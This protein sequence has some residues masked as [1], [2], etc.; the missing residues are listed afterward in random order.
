MPMAKPGRRRGRDARG[1][2]RRRGRRRAEADPM[3]DTSA[4]MA[5]S[6]TPTCGTRCRSRCRRTSPSRPPRAVPSA[7]S[8][9][10]PPASGPRAAPTPTPQLA[11]EADAADKAARKAAQR[12]RPRRRL[13]SS[14]LAWGHDRR[15][16]LLPHLSRA[17]SPA[18]ST[19]ILPDAAA[20]RCSPGGTPRCPR[21]A[22]SG[23]GRRVGHASARPAPSTS[24][25]AAPCTR[26]WSAVERPGVLRLP[27][28]RHPRR[29]EARSSPRL[30]GLWTFEKA[31][32]GIRI[33]WS[34]TV[35]PGVVG[36]RVC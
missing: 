7:P 5:P 15:A 8:T 30:D 2:G 23:P 21:S 16:R 13:L 27:D 14:A 22:R 18:R 36:D 26:R 9:S 25:T 28:H 17:P 3:A 11:R 4:G 33:T 29:P 19:T 12:R 32:T 24:P 34:W 31:G 1:P 35:A 10:T 6:S 20:G